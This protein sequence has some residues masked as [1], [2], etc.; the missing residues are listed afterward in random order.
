[1]KCIYGVFYFA[2]RKRAEYF[3]YFFIKDIVN[4]TFGLTN[5]TEIPYFDGD[6]W[7][8]VFEEAVQEDLRA[9]CSYDESCFDEVSDAVSTC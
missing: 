5:I 3:L 4:D 1:M 6:F 9:G 8:N 2:T 7:P